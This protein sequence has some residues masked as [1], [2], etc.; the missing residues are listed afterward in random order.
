MTTVTVGDELQ[1]DGAVAVYDPVLGVLDG[2]HDSED[3][4]T[5]GLE[6][7]SDIGSTGGAGPTY[8]D[9]RDQ[10]TTG[11]VLCVRGATLRRG[12]HTVLVV[13]A[14]EHARQVPEL[15]LHIESRQHSSL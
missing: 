7:Y 13:L 9:T 5:I 1:E 12:T 11:V 2:L 6:R 14:D 4:H 15:R 8:L 10:V 3:I